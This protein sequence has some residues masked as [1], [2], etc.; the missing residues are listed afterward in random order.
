MTADIV[1]LRG[2]RKR[3]ARDA[4]E[5]RAAENRAKFGTPKSVSKLS[6]ALRE[7]ERRDIDGKKRED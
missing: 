6:S 5:E 1:N 2:L 7:K 4:K 3:K